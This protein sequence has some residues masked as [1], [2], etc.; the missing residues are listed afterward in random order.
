MLLIVLSELQ[1][2][3]RH[4]S[5]REAVS[6]LVKNAE[7]L[8]F[9][10]DHADYLE[11]GELSDFSLR[12]EAS[13][14]V[15]TLYIQQSNDKVVVR[16]MTLNDQDQMKRQYVSATDLGELQRVLESE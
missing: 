8:G 4:Q 10:M 13:G 7:R 5:G 9:V 12:R 3:S 6:A 1:K 2:R 15:H 11:P 16:L 14:L